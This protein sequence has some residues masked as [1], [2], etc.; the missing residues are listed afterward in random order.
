M[1]IIVGEKIC[2]V[3]PASDVVCYC[4]DNLTLDNPDYYKKE[5]MGKWTGNIPKQIA[6]YEK[7]GKDLIIPFGCLQ[8][9]WSLCSARNYD[10]AWKPLFGDLR[11]LF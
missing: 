5:R 11:R 4:V 6:L 1:E 7:R 3:N 8:N 10:A 9:L 2:I